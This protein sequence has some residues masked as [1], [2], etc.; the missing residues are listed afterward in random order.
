MKWVVMKFGGSSVADAAN[1]PVIRE[2]IETR[3][4]DNFH[5]VVVLSALQGVTDGL[6]ALLDQAGDKTARYRALQ[7]RHRLLA[8]Q[9]G[10]AS[11]QNDSGWA[12][13]S[14][15]A[16]SREPVGDPR[17][18]AHLLS[19]GER[20]SSLIASRYLVDHGVPAAWLDAREVLRASRQPLSEDDYA[21]LANSVDD[22]AD[23]ALSRRLASASRVHITQGF[24]AGDRNGDAILLGRGGSDTS[25]AILAAK[26]AAKRLEIWTDV[27]GLFSADPRLVPNARLLR[28]LSYEEAQE[29]AFMGAKVLH[30]HCLKPVRR[31]RIPLTIHDI[32]APQQAGTRIGGPMAQ[33]E[34]RIKGVVS[35]ADVTLITLQGQ[36]MWQQAGFLADAFAVFKRHALSVDLIATSEGSVSLT[37]D[38]G[39]LTSKDQQR[40]SAAVSDLSAL[41][42]VR[43]R[44]A[45]VSISLVGKAIRTLL[46]RLSAAL[47]VLQ[48]RRVHMVTQ[49]DND[50]NLT[51]VVDPEHAEALVHKLHRHLIELPSGWAPNAGPN[52][53]E[54]TQTD[55]KPPADTWW[56]NDAGRLIDRC[57]KRDCAYI[58]N[59]EVVRQRA[60]Q[61]LGIQAIDRLLYS[62]KANPHP[63][64][65]RLL[66]ATGVGFECVSWAE[67]RHLQSAVPAIDPHQIL[68][69]PNF[70][71]RK[72]Y[73]RALESGVHL[74]I[75]SLYPLRHWPEFL[76]G[77]K[78]FLRIDLDTGEGHHRKVMT[79]GSR[80]K[81]GIPLSDLEELQALIAKYHIT[82]TGLHT[83]SGSGVLDTTVW[84]R[85]LKQLIGLAGHFPELRVLDIGGGLGVPEIEGERG[86]NL[87]S[88]DRCLAD[89]KPSAPSLELWMEPGRFLVA[90]AGVLLARV[91]QVKEKSGHRF[92]GLATGMNSL[93]RPALY[94][95]YHPI[96]NLSRLEEPATERYTVVGPLCESGDILGESRELP[97]SEEGDLVL[98]GNAGAYGAVLANHYNCRAPAEE[99]VL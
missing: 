73:S 74:T 50:L 47:D 35:R 18:R 75:D 70:V 62:V 22:D 34:A 99:I 82:V 67:V 36:R 43:V 81:F 94:G 85:Q 20:W 48:D 15:A 98:I 13:L 33:G 77:R 91:T 56:R 45:C 6:T 57:G 71:P 28:Q 1:W 44:S 95:A 14:A 59:L 92:L 61:L 41:C 89:A 93:M 3:L 9:L 40:L 64:I 58:Y 23:T 52:W 80:S 31:H 72:E 51:L 60:Q 2:Q 46:G 53:H 38:P 17:R 68:I 37:L 25:A 26:L 49:S 12:D 42:R 87:H 4:A 16:E 29:F 97:V 30:P 86:L 24:V 11:V 69:T 5:V 39:A 8:D 90:E 96:V 32:R 10:T 21:W 83:H 88:L 54:L 65:L 19:L 76:A 27:P 55:R 78:V 84:Q 63:E 66:H 79:A 7:E